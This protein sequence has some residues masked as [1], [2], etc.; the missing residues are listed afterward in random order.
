MFLLKTP[1]LGSHRGGE[2]LP[3]SRS[4]VQLLRSEVDGFPVDNRGP[5]AGDSLR[6]RWKSSGLAPGRPH[7]PGIEPARLQ[8]GRLRGLLENFQGSEETF[9]HI[10]SVLCHSSL[11][12]CPDDELQI[13]IARSHGAPPIWPPQPVMHLPAIVRS[14]ALR[15]R[16]E[17]FDFAT[18][19]RLAR[20]L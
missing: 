17:R 14:R 8:S 20:D 16:R 2:R 19:L 1:R 5:P 9:R 18:C 13:P 7:L 15:L 12:S 4:A 10:Q 11:E 3:P 6:L